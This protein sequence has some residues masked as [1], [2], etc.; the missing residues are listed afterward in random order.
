VVAQTAQQ[1]IDTAK[2]YT[3]CDPGYCLRYVRTWLGI[4]SQQA[5]AIDAWTTA[6]HK[7]PD[8]RNPP[9]GAPCFYRGGTYGHI[10]LAMR[11]NQAGDAMMRSTD[12]TSR[13]QVSSQQLGWCETHWG[14]DYLGWTEDLNGVDI[15]YL[16]NTGPTDGDQDMPISDEDLAKIAKRVNATLGDYGADGE[17]RNADNPDPE[18]GNARLNQIEQIVRRLE[19]KLDQL[20]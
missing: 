9:P 8:D 16:R 11:D 13:A 5:S 7:H 4:G 6:R 18:T 14:Y 19:D 1:A 20:T 2:R 15:P 3:S 10:V 12:C 17:P